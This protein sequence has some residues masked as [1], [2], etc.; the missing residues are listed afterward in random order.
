MPP[1]D[2]PSIGTNDSERRTNIIGNRAFRFVC[3]RCRLSRGEEARDYFWGKNFRGR[4]FGFTLAEV[5]ITLGII[6][7]VAALTIPTLV[8]NYQK[9][10][11]AKKVKKFYSM[12]NNALQFSIAENGDVAS[13]MGTPKNLTYEENL[14]FMKKYFLPYIKYM[15]YDNCYENAVCVYTVPNSMFFFRYD[16]NGGDFTYFVN[17]KIEDRR[18]RNVFAFQFNKN[19]GFYNTEAVIKRRNIKTIIEPYV[20]SWDGTYE[21]LKG[22]TERGCNNP[23]KKHDI[24]SYCTKLLQMNDWK[25]TDDFPWSWN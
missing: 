19:N 15:K 14:D 24:G 1:P 16:M 9:E 11:T 2:E 10:T 5:L 12:I 22:T 17:G 4:K 13:W 23:A 3:E 25:I 18:R 8:T 21:T 20:Y 7:V 6:G